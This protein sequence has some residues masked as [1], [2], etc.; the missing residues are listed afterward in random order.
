MCFKFRKAENLRILKQIKYFQDYIEIATD[1]KASLSLHLK[2]MWT[3]RLR[4]CSMG[5]W[6]YRISS[7]YLSPVSSC[8]EIIKQWLTYE[9]WNK[10][11]YF[12][13]Q[14]LQSAKTC[15]Q[16]WQI[17]GP[18]EGHCSVAGLWVQSS[19]WPW[20]STVGYECL[21][22]GSGSLVPSGPA[23]W[24]GPDPGHWHGAVIW[25]G[26]ELTLRREKNIL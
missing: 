16:I 18:Q 1:L 11:S 12:I 2:K 14:G 13:F 10:N 26:Q 8:Q 17:A 3:T 7:V 9:K 5:R 20:V 6:V 21:Q 15:K 23:S 24:L 22:C 19:R 4:D 25:T